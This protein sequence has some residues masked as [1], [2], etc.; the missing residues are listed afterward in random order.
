MAVF[1]ASNGVVVDRDEDGSLRAR[2]VEGHSDVLWADH[3]V[4]FREYFA[5]EPKA[6]ES[7]KPGE[8][9]ALTMG[10]DVQAYVFSENCWWP[11]Y[12]NALALDPLEILTVT[13]GRRIWPEGGQS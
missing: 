7:A 2:S 3:E 5:Q 13:A 4:A 6:W 10:R 9:W 8:V 11:L 1:T 12:R